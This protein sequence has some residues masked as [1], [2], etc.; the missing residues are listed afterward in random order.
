[1]G[2][3]RIELETHQGVITKAFQQAPVGAGMTT[4]VTTH[5]RIFF[6]IDWM[7]ADGSNNRAAVSTGNAMH[8]GEVIP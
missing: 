3:T 6:P 4:G 5:H 2:A 7:S 1:M 8:N